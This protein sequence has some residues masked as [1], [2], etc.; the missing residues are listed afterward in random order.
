MFQVDRESRMPASYDRH[1]WKRK[2]P[3]R[4]TNRNL[5]IAD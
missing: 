1:G 5:W 4:T 2:Q 3:G